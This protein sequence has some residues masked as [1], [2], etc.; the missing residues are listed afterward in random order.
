MT[1]KESEQWVGK[2]VMNLMRVIA[3]LLERVRARPHNNRVS[4]W[5]LPDTDKNSNRSTRGQGR[6]GHTVEFNRFSFGLCNTRYQKANEG[7]KSKPRDGFRF[8]S[9]IVS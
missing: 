7:M 9:F 1:D 6:K 8:L 3:S 4:Q 5:P 2:G